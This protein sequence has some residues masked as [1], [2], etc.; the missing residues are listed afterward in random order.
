MLV[1]LLY[2]SAVP[3]N[4][5]FEALAFFFT[6]EWF[7]KEKNAVKHTSVPPLIDTVCAEKLTFWPDTSL[8]F[9]F[10]DFGSHLYFLTGVELDWSGF[11]SSIRFYFQAGQQTASIWPD[12]KGTNRVCTVLK[13]N[14]D[15]L[16][17][18][19]QWLR[20]KQDGFGVKRF[21]VETQIHY[22]GGE[23]NQTQ[24]HSRGKQ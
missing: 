1:Q 24:I 23:G 3:H 15:H 2:C 13:G 17:K 7:K 8:R 12:K 20:R 18:L 22:N 21:I 19:I 6:S 16:S 10:L 11:S 9:L 14:S 5:Q 4:S